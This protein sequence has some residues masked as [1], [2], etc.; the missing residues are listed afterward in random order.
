MKNQLLLIPLSFFLLLACQHSTGQS[1]DTLR[2]AQLFSDHMVIQRDAEI[3][4]WGW[5]TA[6]AE[7]TVRFKGYQRR[8]QCGEDGRWKVSLPAM[9]AGGPFVL[10]IS[11]KDQQLFF[12][13]VFVGDVWLCS[14]QSNMEWSVFHSQNFEQEMTQA[15]DAKIRHFKVAR[16]SSLLPDPELPD[17][18]WKVCSTQ[19][20]GDFTAVGYFFAREL[21]KS[22]NVPI[23]L[24][25]SS[26]G[27][28]RIEAWMSAASLGYSSSA[29]AALLIGEEEKSQL[30]RIT[31]KLQ[32]T[33]GSI[34]QKDEGKLPD[35]SVPY[36][37]PN[38]PTE[39]WISLTTP[40]LWE[41]SGF[42]G[43]DGIAWYRNS[44]DL[45]PEEAAQGAFLHLAKIDDS[46]ICWIN[47]REVGGMQNSYNVDRVYEVPAGVLQAGSNV[48]AVRVED[49]GGG[50]GI[51]GA[52][53][54]LFLQSSQR[55]IPLAGEWKFKISEA[56]LSF[57][58]GEHHTPTRIYNKMIHP[59]LGFPIKGALW[60]QGE[61]NAGGEDAVA[62]ADQFQSMIIDW[63]Q[64]M[65]SGDFPFL[66]V[67]LANF[68]KPDKQPSESSWAV[69]RESQ[70]K[71]LQLPA[72]AQAVIIDIGDADDIHPRNKQDV[73]LRLSLAARKIAYGEENL[74]YSG[75]TY[76]SMR[77]EGNRIR[78]S[79]DHVGGGLMAREGEDQLQGFAIASAE[80]DYVWAEARIEGDEIVVWSDKI[81]Q[82]TAVR[83]AWANNPATANLYNKEGLPASPFRTDPER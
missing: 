28:S 71:A 67:Q 27:G 50:G 13:D 15:N 21:R 40:G 78:L 23:G 62:Y 74:V 16:T 7:V 52:P 37:D 18:E 61:S 82:P 45:S 29:E 76:R 1:T 31:E 69:L 26:W 10:D 58:A 14:G 51:Y 72:T 2:A 42:E 70:S 34:P 48:I 43:V 47:G 81:A 79:F 30:E 57:T 8:T 56:S 53:E 25:N 68:T 83:Y 46:D 35:G 11:S 39:D 32:Q 41:G 24:L 49:T 44:F 5:A 55:R 22:V 33:F 6:G 60:Y 38:L 80:G 19:T 3:P 73:G 64:R 54:E 20:V 17:G 12:Q 77:T 63:R 9:P 65:Q 59:W 36:A 75:P 66:F 4:V